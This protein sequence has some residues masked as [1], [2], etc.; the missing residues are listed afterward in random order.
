MQILSG[1]FLQ[2]KNQPIQVLV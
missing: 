2:M 1:T